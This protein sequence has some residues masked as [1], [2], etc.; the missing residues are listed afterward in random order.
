MI[1]ARISSLR[2][3]L[4]TVV[5]T[6][7]LHRAGRRKVPYPVVAIVGYTNA[8]KS[9]LFN[10]LTGAKVFAKQ[11]V[12]ATLDPTMREVR[13]SSGRR[14]ILSDTVGFIS[15]LPTMLVA[16]F[17]ATLEETRRASLALHVIDASDPCRDDKIIQVN[18]VLREIGA[19]DLPQI[20]V[21][22]KI[23]A[24][25]LAARALNEEAAH[26]VPPNEN[27]NGYSARVWVSARESIGL[28]VL[29]RVIHEFFR[30]ATVQRLVR[31]PASAGRLR[32]RLYELGT[33]V[34]EQVQDNGD[35]LIQIEIAPASLERLWRRE[36]LASTLISTVSA[37]GNGNVQADLPVADTPK[38]P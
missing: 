26:S 10:Y 9:T 5:K 29:I 3:E 21:Y 27:G 33:V 8:G 15:D 34:Q 37:V 17:R 4:N 11:Q 1:N 12:F 38:A 30:A 24:C 14:A 13:L 23:D 31:L 20:R 6:R 22:N 19:G 2:K 18:D 36:G 7:A 32:A 35:W 16:A 28:D 25:H